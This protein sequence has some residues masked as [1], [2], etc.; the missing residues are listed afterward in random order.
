MVAQ[1]K[2]EINLG[3]QTRFNSSFLPPPGSDSPHSGLDFTP[4]SWERTLDPKTPI[5]VAL[6]GLSGGA[7]PSLFMPYITPD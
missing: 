5:I 2:P 1:C 3:I 4:P 7:I 6:H